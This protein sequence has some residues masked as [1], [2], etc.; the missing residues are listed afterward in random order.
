MNEF[1]EARKAYEDIPVPEELSRCVQ[2]GIRRG[3]A[4]R[5][6]RMW[7]KRLAAVAACLAVTVG[8]LN[9]SPAMASAAAD[10]PVLGGLFRVLTVRSYE[11]ERDQIVYHVEVPEVQ[12]ESTIVQRV[13]EEI[14]Q[15]VDTH[16]AEAKDMWEEY[17][18]A[19][20]ATG[21]TEKEWAERTL[22][23][24]VTYNIKSQT[25]TAISFAV[26]MSQSSVSASQTQ[27]YYNL[28]L[29][30]PEGRDITLWDL[31]GDDWINICNTSIQTQIDASADKDGFTY[32][33]APEE[34]G[35]TTMDETTNFYID[36]SGVP[37]V[38]FPKYAIA[39][40]A[41]GI[42]EFPISQ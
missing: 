4:N 34:G 25:D 37:V 18:K 42:V 17:H 41:A 32:F 30:S 33:F 1:Q 40:G 26:D 10:I 22:D 19:F 2:A 9:L 27:Y 31:L 39:A 15:R 23:L 28:D 14:Q 7:G 12:A 13:N 11:T 3:K 21:G 24:T 20:L 35:F 16:I 38:V 8:V 6:R 5:L 29:S 36:R